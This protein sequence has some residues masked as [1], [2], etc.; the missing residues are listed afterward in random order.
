MN[1]R[2]WFLLSLAC[3]LLIASFPTIALASPTAAPAAPPN[4]RLD[5]AFTISLVV[6]WDKPAY[7]VKEYIVYKN[8][9]EYKR[10]GTTRFC[11]VEGLTAGITYSLYVKAVDI[12]GN[13]S[14]PSPTINA[15]TKATNKKFSRPIQGGQAKGYFTDIGIDFHAPQGTSCLAAAAGKV[16]FAGTDP[17][18]GKMVIIDLTTKPSYD[19]FT[20]QRIFYSHLKEIKVTVGDTVSTG[21]VVGT[22]GTW[23]SVNHLHFGITVNAPNIYYVAGNTSWK[24]DWG[25][26]YGRDQ[27]YALLG[28]TKME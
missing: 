4:F 20:A 10:T 7:S 26:N 22:S 15:T 17:S 12:N 25:Y 13:V 1:T 11:I 8:N 19:G 24:Y 14:N 2:R 16:T 18:V 9:V 5:R 23:N 6:T 27:V 21:T 28:L 3:V